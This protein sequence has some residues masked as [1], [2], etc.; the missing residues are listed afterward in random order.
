[1]Q[2]LKA[3]DQRQRQFMHSLK[4]IHYEAVDRILRYLEGTLGKGILF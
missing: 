2:E 4:P 1:M 3:K